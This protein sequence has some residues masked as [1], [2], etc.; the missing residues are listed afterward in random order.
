[1]FSLLDE[2]WLLG[3]DVEGNS[4]DFSLIEAFTRK[5]PIAELIGDS[6]IQNYSITKLLITIASRTFANQIEIE[7]GDT[8]DFS[9][10]FEE[11]LEN[12]HENHSLPIAVDYL[13]QYRN[14]FELVDE[15]TPF[16][17]VSNLRTN[18]NTP[19]HITT[20]IP[21]AQSDYFSMRSGAAR[22]S[23]PLGEA[24]RWL[25]TTQAFDISGIK[26]GAIGDARVK[27]GKGY[28]IG[29]GWSGMTG[30]TLVKGTTLLE[31]LL[32]N[33]T[34]ECLNTSNDKP[35]WERQPDGPGSR[36]TVGEN[37]FPQ[38][39]NDL[40][41]WQS[42]R[43]K[44]QVEDDRATGVTLCIGDKIPDAGANVLDDPST[45]YRFSKNKSK[46][47]HTVYYPR[48]YDAERTIWRSLDSL[49]V[50][51]TDAGFSENAMAPLRPRVLS[52]LAELS[53]E[54]DGI[55]EVL[56]VE[57]V[58]M[59]YGP[60]DSSVKNT[61]AATMSL[62]L[63]ALLE[64]NQLIRAAI[65]QT[66]AATHSAGIALGQFAGHLLEAA[67]EKYEFQVVI[68]DQIMAELE[69]RFNVWLAS[70][71]D[72]ASDS[73]QL[74]RLLTEWQVTARK[75]IEAHARTLLRGAGPR[76]LIGRITAAQDETKSGKFISA[77]NFYHLLL[78]NLDKELPRTAKQSPEKEHS[79]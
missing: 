20:L 25:V 14:R 66:A 8:F 60:Q 26:T 11:T 6:P 77:A 59:E 70:L 55:P 76:A 18:V 10:W 35:V 21:E 38:G 31:T 39:P 53:E 12:L 58:S 36:D 32:F 65:R 45:P 57:L 75:E 67:G 51:E 16:M 49:I 7:A 62:P 69:P 74:E 73:V 4:V 9:E 56:Q 15:A 23:V 22:D 1:M 3:K 52:N 19:R 43:I 54:I 78:R 46:K 37:P 27:E 28:P 42:R 13:E 61:Y 68:T 24:A 50:S 79:Q 17:Q 63:V 41:T 72:V 47:D 5:I 48:P 33:I 44:L 2:P 40:A 71:Q 34:P 29:T 30:G 64:K